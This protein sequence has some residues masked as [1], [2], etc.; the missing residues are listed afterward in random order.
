[1][2]L[3]WKIRI[4]NSDFIN[5]LFVST[6]NAVDAFKT[7]AIEQQTIYVRLIRHC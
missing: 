7:A 5:N 4:P 1:M 6:L 3:Y 2:D